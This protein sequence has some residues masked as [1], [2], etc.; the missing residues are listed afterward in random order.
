MFREKTNPAKQAPDTAFLHELNETLW[1]FHII[2]RRL[3][4]K[5]DGYLSRETDREKL[6]AKKDVR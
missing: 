5:L 6:P 4:R 2:T 1:A 3:G